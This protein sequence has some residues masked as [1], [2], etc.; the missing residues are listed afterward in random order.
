MGYES[1]INLRKR[2]KVNGKAQTEANML[3]QKLNFFFVTVIND[4]VQMWGV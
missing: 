3:A 2:G 4:Y 1:Y